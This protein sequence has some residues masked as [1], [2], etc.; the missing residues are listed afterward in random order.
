MGTSEYHGIIFNVD[1]WDALGRVDLSGQALRVSRQVYEEANKVLYGEN[2]FGIK[3]SGEG[4]GRQ[5]TASFGRYLQITG[6]WNY[7]AIPVHRTKK[8][9]IVVELRSPLASQASWC[10]VRSTCLYLARVP[11]LTQIN[12]HLQMSSIVPA[13]FGNILDPFKILRNVRSVTFDEPQNQQTHIT[14]TITGTPPEYARTLKTMMEG[15]ALACPL[16]AM[17]CALQEYT[18]ESDRY[19]TDLWKTFVAVQDGDCEKFQRMALQLVDKVNAH[20]SSTRVDLFR[21]G[22]SPGATMTGN[23]REGTK[24]MHRRGS[25]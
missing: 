10:L 8:Y 14:G 5:H 7:G 23:K 17:F 6:I 9:S 22:V 3:I 11:E 24:V 1:G 20:M 25:L 18:L 12:I 16:P 13:S 21:Y 15:P 4:H 2:T 19:A